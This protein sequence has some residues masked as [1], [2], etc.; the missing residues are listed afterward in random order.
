MGSKRHA[1]GAKAG[2]RWD[3]TAL[4]VDSGWDCRTRSGCGQWDVGWDG[5][6][7]E[8]EHRNGW[9]TGKDGEEAGMGYWWRWGTGKDGVQVAARAKGMGQSLPHLGG[10][11]GTEQ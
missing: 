8:V 6:Q 11:S 7:A 5:V 4:M 3:L 1:G 2:C 10:T 9:G